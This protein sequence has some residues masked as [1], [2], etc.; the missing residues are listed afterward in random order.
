MLGSA[1]SGRLCAAKVASA[2]SVMPMPLSVPLTVNRPPENS[3]S[4][5]LASSRCAANDLGLLD[6]LVGREDQRLTTDDERARAVGVQALGRDLGVAV[7]HL[8]VLE[9]H[10]EPVGDDLA[11]RRLVA[12]AVRGGAGETSTL[13]VASIRMLA[14]SQPPAP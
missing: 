11:P 2:M 5:T 6:H 10:A 9:R 1:P 4:S 13:P 14:C 12:L 7:Q 8:D 3:R